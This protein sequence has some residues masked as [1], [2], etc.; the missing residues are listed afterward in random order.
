MSVSFSVDDNYDKY[1]E[2]TR[3]DSEVSQNGSVNEEEESIF[4]EEEYYETADD[5]DTLENLQ[6]TYNLY[7]QAEAEVFEYVNAYGKAPSYQ[8]LLG[9]YNQGWITL[10]ENSGG[11]QYARDV[12][13]RLDYYS[14]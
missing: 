11:V 9:A 8:V 14:V 2:S 3:R 4:S 7:L 6:N 10:A 5:N 13:S 12:L 1:L